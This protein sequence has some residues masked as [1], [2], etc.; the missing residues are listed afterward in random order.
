MPLIDRD[1]NE[2]E[3]NLMERFKSNLL[4]LTES[5]TG[6]TARTYFKPRESWIQ[7]RADIKDLREP[8]LLAIHS[9][10]IMRLGVI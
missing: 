3:W 10:I 2:V 6:E 9:G 4:P 8:I 1:G 7:L 5:V